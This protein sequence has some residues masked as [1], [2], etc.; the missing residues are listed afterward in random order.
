MYIRTCARVYEPRRG[1]SDLAQGG[2]KR[3]PGTNKRLFKYIRTP[4]GWKL[5]TQRENK[6]K[7]MVNK[8]RPTCIRFWLPLLRGSH[9]HVGYQTQLKIHVQTHTQQFVELEIGL[10]GLPLLTVIETR[11]EE[12]FR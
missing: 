4:E 7:N 9:L 2:A 6:M 3:N 12:E 11:I 8:I 10:T 5:N 1:D